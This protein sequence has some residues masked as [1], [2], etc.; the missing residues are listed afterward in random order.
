MQ[1]P[2]IVVP[3]AIELTVLIT[4]IA[5]LALF[6]RFQTRPSLG[7]I[8][9]FGSF[10]LAAFS[11]LLALAIAIWSVFDTWQEL[12]L[13]NQPLLHTV[14]FSLAPWLV[15]AMAGISMALLVQRI[16]PLLQ[17][18]TP[19]A[20]SKTLPSREFMDFQGVPVRTVDLPGWFAFTMGNGRSAVIYLSTEP[21]KALSADE[22][23][24]VLWH[25]LGHAK[26][27][28]NSY[29]SIARLI[30]HLGGLMLASKVLVA[31]VDRLTEADADR[32]AQQHCDRALLGAVREMFTS[33]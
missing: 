7:L 13:G 11:T 23:S 8:L 9:W 19:M 22:L 2:L 21:V 17:S 30:S 32:Y 4:T 12:S 1:A 6:G 5:P 3:F 33:S 27:F 15:L 29:K 28:H 31:E 18:K 25:E 26:L 16:E 14:F 10:L 20:F 24:A